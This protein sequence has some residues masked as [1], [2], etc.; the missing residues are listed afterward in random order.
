MRER[1]SGRC[2]GDEEEERKER[3][4]IQEQIEK[5]EMEKGGRERGRQAGRQAGEAH[6]SPPRYRPWLGQ[7]A[8][9]LPPSPPP[10]FFFSLAAVCVCVCLPAATKKSFLPR[11]P[12]NPF[13]LPIFPPFSS[14]SQ[15]KR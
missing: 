8:Y 4:E 15:K 7:F 10:L 5:E 11:P 9:S 14:S 6:P 13:L 12:P 1:G 2:K 3:K